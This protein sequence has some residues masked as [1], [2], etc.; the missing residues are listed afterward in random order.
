V[1]T[2]QQI[3]LT[4]IVRIFIV[5]ARRPEIVKNYLK[6]R[7]ASLIMNVTFLQIILPRTGEHEELTAVNQ[8]EPTGSQWCP[9][10]KGE[11]IRNVRETCRFR[12]TERFVSFLHNRICIQP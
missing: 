3:T 1:P 12:L 7:R 8:H 4:V 6:N 2:V 9:C 10:E 11:L 5:K